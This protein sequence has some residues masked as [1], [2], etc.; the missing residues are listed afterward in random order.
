MD[1]F[2]SLMSIVGNAP[3]SKKDPGRRLWVGEKLGLFSCKSYL[4]LLIDSLNEITF[5][6]HK[7][8]LK[9]GFPPK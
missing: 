7:M 5:V 2:L 4:D 6:P 9:H 3:L 8:I 1:E